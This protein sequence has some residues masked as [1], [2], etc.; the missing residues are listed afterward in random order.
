MRVLQFQH[1]FAREALL[2]VALQPETRV[3]IETLPLDPAKQRVI[4]AVMLRF[5]RFFKVSQGPRQ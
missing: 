4:K 3:L 1:G 5:V 2:F